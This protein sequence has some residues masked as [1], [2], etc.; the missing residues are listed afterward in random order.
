[1]R[2]EFTFRFDGREVQARPGDSIAAALEVAGMRV[3]GRSRA[4]RPRGVFC[5]MGAC[6]DCMVRV[7]GRLSQRA[8]M[9][10]AAP[11]MEV[12]PQVD[13]ATAPGPAAGD[14]P[15]AER[16]DCDV[17]IV[18]AGPA[19]LSAAVVA[20]GAG[21][22]VVVLDERGEPGGQY[23]KPRSPGF[24]GRHAPDGQHAGGDALRREAAASGAVLRCGETIWFARR[25]SGGEGDG[26]EV[27]SVG[28]EGQVRLTSRAVILATGATE[29]PA[30]VP[31]WTLPGV[32]TIGAAQTLARRYGAAPGGRMLIAGNGPLGL[33]LAVELLALGA[34]VAAV[35]ERAPSRP[36]AML[37]AGLA[38]PRLG[39]DGLTMLAR[40]RWA[41]VPV[42]W[43]WQVRR[44][45]GDGRAEAAVI[46]DGQGRSRTVAAETVAMGD[47]FMPQAELAR[48]LGVPVARDGHGMAAPERDDDGTTAVPGLWVGGDAGGLGGAQAAMGQGRLAGA[49]AAR[50]LGRTVSE[51]PADRRGLARAGRFQAALWRAYAAPARATPHGETV[52]CRCEQVTAAT[53]ERAVAAGARDPGAVKRATR[54]GM[55]RCQGRLCTEPLVR[56]LEEAGNEIPPEALF[57]PQVP[58]RTVP[59]APLLVEKGEWGGHRESSPSA[60]PAA[61]PS[62]PLSIDRADLVVVGAGVTGIA[63]AL[64]AA[65]RGARIVCLDRGRVNGEASGGNAGSLHLQL[66]SWDFGAKAFA[67][68]SAALATLPLQKEAI[69]LWCTLEAE[70]G[71]D[72]EMRMTGGLMVAEDERQMSFL[73]RKAEA[74]A[75]VGIETEVVGAAEIRSLVPAIS[76]RMVAGAWCPGEGKINPL[77]ATAALA[78]A[79]RAAGAVIEELAPATAIRAEDGGYRV[80]TPRGVVATQRVVLAS[81]GWSAGLARQLGVAVPVRGA[82]LQMIVTE[83]APPLVP[84]LLAHADRHLTMKQTD[85]GT[86]LIGGAW[87]ARTGPSGQPEILPESLEGNL[88]VAARTVPAVAG[89]S[90]VRSW[91]A[92]NI[93]IDGAPLLSSLPGHPG[94]VVAATANGY[95][96]GPLMGR[97]AAEVALCGRLRADLAPFTLDR[98]AKQKEDV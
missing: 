37:R 6:Q 38:D 10:E 93:D 13:G 42:L 18:G 55:G 77:T 52:L 9:T 95:T 84:C 32:M 45:N 50:H 80:E 11:G 67:D 68:G 72:F 20:A 33:Q 22:R 12:V 53:I 65:R 81:G 66:L 56:L 64:H 43:G 21:L 8:C 5:G 69:A 78:E 76:E 79:A 92:M 97:E 94:V 35:A 82:P 71:A 41:Q 36:L 74:E 87:T 15:A 39:R 46:E 57:A 75:R 31:G 54:C 26:F 62:E 30:M 61:R 17:A 25:S 4:G 91:A 3:L 24:R 70:L 88:W 73:R 51:A 89:L 19:G 28:P 59:V 34:D 1:M 16:V 60:R 86:L 85:A 7:D 2:P 47:G 90:L 58:A 98:F 23:F 48:L 14:A 96:L 27:R 40:L 83:T 29:R 49:A 63:A 44:V